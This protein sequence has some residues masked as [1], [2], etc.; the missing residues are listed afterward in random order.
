M[1][2]NISKIV[3][4][5]TVL[6]FALNADVKPAQL[7]M[8]H[9][10]IQREIQAPV[11]GIADPGEKVKVSA[12]WGESAETIADNN[13]KWLVKIQTP[14]AGGPH[15]LSLQGKNKIELKDV[16]SGDV[17]LCSGQSNMGWPVSKSNNAA[18]EKV[19]A[20]YPHIR[21]FKVE[22]KPSL[23][24]LEDCRGEW[25]VCSPETVSEFS[26]TAYFTG[27][28]LHKELN[29]PIGLLTT[30][31][32][33]TGVEAWTPWADQK[34]DPFALAKKAAQDKKAQSYSPENAKAN[35]EKKMLRWK[36]NAELAK[37]SKKR[38]PRKPTLGQDP[39]LDQNYPGNLYNGMLH[40]LVPF[41]VKGIM[42]Y[43]GENNAKSIA[44]A[45]NYRFQLTKMI[46][47][48][49]Q[50]WKEEIPFYSV[51]L[52]NFRGPQVNPVEHKDIWPAMRES[53]VYAATNTAKSYTVTTIDLGEAKN[54]HP[55]NKQDVGKRLASTIL[56]KT[57][58]KE[59]PTTPF[60]KSYTIEAGKFL[61]KF[62][63]TGSGLITKNGQL[64][65]FA[66]AGSDKKFVWA[67]AEIITR[68]GSEYV[69][70][71]SAKIKAPVAVRYA[72]ANNPTESNLYSKEGFPASP[73]RTDKWKLSVK[74]K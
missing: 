28:K 70:V 36:Q 43:Q 6:P 14:K 7:F 68:D 67:D 8:D 46:K 47:S 26:A 30:C 54:I 10:V 50:V 57:Y 3:L 25:Q 45:E 19:K 51:Q 48:W 58:G 32:G 11:W 66:I 34:D 62:D 38:S 13:G 20:H 16:L 18:E 22:R 41:A 23:K 60:M 44:S 42:W 72:W 73:F 71:S 31:W 49:R 74:A 53:F 17:W 24:M 1:K 55:G 21:S 52:P 65:G 9:M 40:P 37:K 2:L 56:N 29:V 33:G 59:T 15:S 4:A 63:Y 69:S 39:L 64:K 61:I 35:Y 5:F 27:R 12:S